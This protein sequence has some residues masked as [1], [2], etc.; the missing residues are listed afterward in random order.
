M[1]LR[2]EKQSIYQ[3]SAFL[4]PAEQDAFRKNLPKGA[5][6]F[7][8][9]GGFP[10]AER[11]VLVCGDE[12][13]FGYPPEPPLAVLSIAPAHEKF[14]E[15]LTHR[16]FLGALMSL[17][18]ERAQLGDIV[19]RDG[20]AYLIC[21]EPISGY[22]AGS[23]TSVRRTAVKV[24]R[25]EGPVPAL[26]PELQEMSLN[27]A[28]ERLDAVVAAFCRL[29]RG[30][31]DQLFAAEKVFVNGLPVTDRACR[32]KEGDR[33]SVRGFGKAIYDGIGS[34][35]KKGRLYVRLRKF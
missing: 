14:A 23:L 27:V 4:T 25:E 19:I 30:K 31:A 24:R 33:F 13:T 8:F 3:Y 28:S 22:I 7:A 35:T 34:E 29:A 17:G 21:L 18:I 32:L 6:P 16:D 5:L 9:D 1:Y 20:T 12:E 11:R 10:E 15:D 2:A 26:E